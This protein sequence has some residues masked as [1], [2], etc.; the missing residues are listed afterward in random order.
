MAFARLRGAGR[1]RNTLLRNYLDWIGASG[2]RD[3]HLL[4]AALL[5]DALSAACRL[6]APA[7]GLP[8]VVFSLGV[9]AAVAKLAPLW[10]TAAGLVA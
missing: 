6:A 5:C 2:T 10:A 1:A 4:A 3:A 9:A 8:A 7:V